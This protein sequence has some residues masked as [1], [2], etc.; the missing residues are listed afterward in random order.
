MEWKP[1]IDVEREAAVDAAKQADIV[2]AFV[3]LSPDLEG[4]EMPVH[5]EGFDG[6]DRTGIEL[7]AVQQQLLEALTATG[8][9]LVVVLM[10]GSALAVNWAK[11]HANAVVEAWYPGEEAGEA[12]ADVLTGKTNPSGRLPV[13]FYAA[14]KDLPLFDDYSMSNRT[15][16]YFRGTPLWGL[17]LWP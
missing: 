16:R 1:A 4:E 14:T 12:I 11:Q 9:P 3:G 7:P 17:R 15:Y 13:T 2:L 10:N 6:G 8:K 5:V